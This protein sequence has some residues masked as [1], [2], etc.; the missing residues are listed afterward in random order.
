MGIGLD[1]THSIF[2]HRQKL[3]WNFSVKGI[4]RVDL[5]YI[6]TVWRYTNYFTY[7]L[8]AARCEQLD[9]IFESFKELVNEEMSAK[10]SVG[11]MTTSGICAINLV[12]IRVIEDK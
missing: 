3:L 2:S 9:V 7:L 1:P 10:L 8:F 4:F 5:G 11:S 12:L 6:R